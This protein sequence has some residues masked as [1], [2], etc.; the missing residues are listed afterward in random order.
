MTAPMSF[1]EQADFLDHMADRT[2]CRTGAPA[3]ETMMLVTAADVEALRAMAQRL[4]RMAPHERSIRKVV[5]G[6]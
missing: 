5:V 2:T 4:R 1:Y 3:A 6:R